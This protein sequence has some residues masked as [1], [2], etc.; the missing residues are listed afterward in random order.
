MTDALSLHIDPKDFM[1]VT[2]AIER[3]QLPIA[4][5]WAL[6]DTA[7]DVLEHIQRRMEVVFD[8][9]TR[10]TKNAFMVW[11]AKKSTLVAE[12][13][14]RPSVGSRHYLKRQERGGVRKQTG[15][16]RM[17]MHNLAYDG[18][19]AAIIPTSAARLNAFG[20]WT[21]GERNQ[22]VSAIKAFGETGY[23]AN[24]T[25]KSKA[26]S[27]GRR[28]AYFVPQKGSGLSPGIWRRKGKGKRERV[29]KIAH[30]T[31]TMPRYHER[32]GFYDG[33]EQVFERMI[34]PNFRRAFEKAM[35]TAR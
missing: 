22:A 24:A 35:A 1:R 2:S 30:F 19:L 25:A 29:E 33:A 27:K 21:P 3:K 14:E 7:D 31:D 4:T 18:V 9:P 5:A 17:V 26:R 11:R 28:A 20:N 12:V 32:L 10:F 8:R 34:A 16:E 13:R 6:N 15:L 23:T